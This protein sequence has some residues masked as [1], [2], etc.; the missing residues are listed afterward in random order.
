LP[1]SLAFIVAVDKLRIKLD[2]SAHQSGPNLKTMF[3]GVARTI[4]ALLSTSDKLTLGPTVVLPMLKPVIAREVYSPPKELNTMPD[5]ASPPLHASIG[6]SK[7]STWD[8][9]EGIRELVDT[10]PDL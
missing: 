7:V 8:D 10:F 6:V 1:A 9:A 3:I 2:E 4:V 5:R